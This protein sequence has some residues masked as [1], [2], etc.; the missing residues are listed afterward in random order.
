MPGTTRIIL[1]LPPH[2]DRLA[3]MEFLST[4][5]GPCARK[6]CRG[7]K[8]EEKVTEAIRYTELLVNYQTLCLQLALWFSAP[9]AV[10][11]WRALLE[12]QRE[13]WFAMSAELETKVNIWSSKEDHGF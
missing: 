11:C 10:L 8:S 1:R 6:S 7:R 5:R 12:I 4:D 2:S 13:S 3:L 9:I